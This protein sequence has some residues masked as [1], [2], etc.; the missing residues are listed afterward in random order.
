MIN[1]SYDKI[2]LLRDSHKRYLKRKLCLKL[3]ITQ[4]ER[5]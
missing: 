4:E 5:E 3:L 1:L 2:E